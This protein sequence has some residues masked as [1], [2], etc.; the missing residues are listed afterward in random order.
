[1]HRETSQ[2]NHFVALRDKFLRLKFNYILYFTHP[3][4]ELLDLVAPFPGSDKRHICHF[5]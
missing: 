1:M 3:A 2:H 4:E 5:W